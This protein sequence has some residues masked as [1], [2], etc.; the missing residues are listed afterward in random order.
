MTNINWQHNLIIKVIGIISAVIFFLGFSRQIVVAIRAPIISQYTMILTTIIF[1]PLIIL[2][3]I[4]F[5]SRFHT[6]DKIDKI[7]SAA[8]LLAPIANVILMLLFGSLWEAIF[9]TYID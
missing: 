5:V 4:L 7:F 2:Q 1:I 9:H 8:T 6:L 3:L